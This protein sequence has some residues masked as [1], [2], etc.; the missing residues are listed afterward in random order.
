MLGTPGHLIHLNIFRSLLIP[1]GG[2]CKGVI[3]QVILIPT[4]FLTNGHSFL[5]VKGDVQGDPDHV[6]IKLN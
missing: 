6:P 2:F 3:I 5:R 4:G 1:G